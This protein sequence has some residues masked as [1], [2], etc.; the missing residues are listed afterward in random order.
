MTNANFATSQKDAYCGGGKLYSAVSSNIEILNNDMK[1][2]EQAVKGYLLPHC[3]Y[4]V[5]ELLLAE[6]SLVCACY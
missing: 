1:V 6:A 5:E 2:F 3:S 4:C